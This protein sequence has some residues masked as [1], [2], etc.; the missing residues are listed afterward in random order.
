MPGLTR[1][2]K[3]LAGISSGSS[4]AEE[5]T[6]VILILLFILII[7]EGFGGLEDTVSHLEG[8]L[9]IQADLVS[10]AI[11]A[12]QVPLVLIAAL[13]DLAIK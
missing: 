3:A 10:L 9:G 11:I 12:A 13:G 6:L 1:R 4:S 8:S 5:A 2:M 7:E